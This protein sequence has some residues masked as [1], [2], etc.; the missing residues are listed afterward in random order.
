M[1]LPCFSDWWFK[2]DLQ[3]RKT[4][5]NPFMLGKIFLVGL[6]ESSARC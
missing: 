5:E 2:Q 1:L 4:W 3:K 6:Q